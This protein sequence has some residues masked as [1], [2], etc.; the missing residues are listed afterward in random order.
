MLMP[1]W[2]MIK[3]RNEFTIF[4]KKLLMKKLDKEV[5]VNIYIKQELL[6]KDSALDQLELISMKGNK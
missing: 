3:D 2:N 4:N 6:L 5:L 1:V